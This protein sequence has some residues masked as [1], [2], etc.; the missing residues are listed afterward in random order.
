MQKK[1][2]IIF[3]MDGTLID[4]G[5]VITNT[6]NYVR[7]NIGLD[8]IPK[9]EMLDHLN[10]PDINAAE[11]FYGTSAFTDEQTK[12]FG[13]YYDK[14]CVSDI[15]L[16]DGIKEMLSSINDDFILTVATN[17]S[18]EFAN[19]MLSHLDIGNYFDMVIG[20]NNVPKPKP[21][22]DMLLK[23]LEKF[24]IKSKDTIF[25]GDSHKDKRAAQSANIDC[26]LVNW[27]FT[28][29]LKEESISTTNE[30]QKAL[31]KLR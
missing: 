23:I 25:V 16:Y 21:N 4:S 6:I 10:N 29:H 7:N 20:A 28:E 8:S 17:A 12:L 27:G 18:V 3:D 26:L 31:L 9:I 14:N 22:P 15:I 5:N 13:E 2:L 1:E 30:L 24:N 19:K 11:F